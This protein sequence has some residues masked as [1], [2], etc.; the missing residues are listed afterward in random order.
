MLSAHIFI[1]VISSS[2][3]DP[4]IIRKEITALAATWM[5]LEIIMLSE[6]SQAV[7]HQHHMLSFTCGIKKKRT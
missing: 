6:V 3:I 7:R 2:W 4:L 5:D 1:I